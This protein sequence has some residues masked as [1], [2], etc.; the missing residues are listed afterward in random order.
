MFV[1]IVQF[2]INIS[3]LKEYR[4]FYQKTIIT[5]LQEMPGCQFVGLIQS[6]SHQD[7][8]ISM[9]FWDTQYHADSFEKSGVYK[10]LNQ[11]SKPF[12]S[13]ANE[14]KIEL[15]EDLKLDYKP[16]SDEPTL[17]EYMVTAQTASQNA[18]HPE[19]P[20][21]YVRFVAHKIKDGKVAEFKRLYSEEI[22]PVLKATRGCRFV[23][24]TENY[25]E[26]REFISVTIWDS[27]QDAQNYETGG[28]FEELVKKIKHT[29]SD[30][31]QWK[32]ALEKDTSGQVTTSEDLSISHY[33]VV[34]G[35]RF[36]KN[37]K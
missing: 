13:E 35:K 15:S 26:K 17:K 20:K 37:I 9:T 28:Q 36:N 5:K 2:K 29:F 34:T 3:L 27:Q 14:W 18:I 30:L 33:S 1:R 4:Q 6:S 11:Q 19:N 24:L 22:L 8:F 7:E 25:R 21:M 10:N 32:M 23:Y 16:I 31:C 12:Y